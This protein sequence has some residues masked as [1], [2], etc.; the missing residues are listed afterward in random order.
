M[1]V[2]FVYPKMGGLFPRMPINLSITPPL[3]IMYLG[4]ICRDNGFDVK[5]I[6]LT[7][8]RNWK[9]Y[10]KRIVKQKPDVIGIT[11]LSPFYNDVLKA[12][13]IAKEVIPQTKIIVCGHHATAVPMEVIKN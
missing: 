6:D 10:K 12:I 1:K 4:A 9:A 7:F 5:L 2:A 3:G 11:A 8:D 13:E